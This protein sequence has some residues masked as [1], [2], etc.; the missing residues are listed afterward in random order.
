M[1]KDL[2]YP[3]RHYAP[4]LLVYTWRYGGHVGCQEQKRVVYHVSFPQSVP[5]ICEGYVLLKF[6]RAVNKHS[7]K[8]WTGGVLHVYLH[9]Y[10][11]HL[12]EGLHDEL[13][14]SWS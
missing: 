4:V 6:F 3:T 9:R 5:T 7:S 10:S 1:R 8:Q 14:S 13:F 2:F 12:A 11:G